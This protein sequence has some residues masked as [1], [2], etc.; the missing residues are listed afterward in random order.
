MDVTAAERCQVALEH[1]RYFEALNSGV[2]FQAMRKHLGWYCRGFPGAADMRTQLFTT[3]SSG[4]VA[5]VLASRLGTGL[6]T[7]CS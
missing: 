1:A 4:D 2:P 7:L 5:R 6:P 3:T